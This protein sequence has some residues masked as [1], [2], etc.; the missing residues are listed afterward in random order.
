MTDGTEGMSSFIFTECSVENKKFICSLDFL[1]L[2]A[3]S[4][5]VKTKVR[6]R[7][8]NDLQ[9]SKQCNTNKAVTN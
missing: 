7:K 6:Q 3:P 8:Q 5:G 9:T 4:P 1:L 2:L